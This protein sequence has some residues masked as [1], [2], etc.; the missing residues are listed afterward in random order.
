VATDGIW[1]GVVKGWTW[2]ICG[3]RRNMGRCGE[4]LDMENMWLQTEQNAR[5]TGRCD[6]SFGESRTFSATPCG[7]FV[8]HILY[9]MTINLTTRIK[10]ILITKHDC[11]Q[12]I[13]SLCHLGNQFHHKSNVVSLSKSLKACNSCNLHGL[14]R[15]SFCRTFHIVV[16]GS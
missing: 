4:G 1:R 12:A 9:I 6:V 11:I 7:V 5:L 2:R 13:F 16:F 3:N 10:I 8:S 14:Q 15:N